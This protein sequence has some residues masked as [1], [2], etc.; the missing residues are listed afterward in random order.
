MAFTGVTACKLAGPP[1]GPFHRRLQPY[2][3]LYGCSDCYRLE[4]KLPGGT[5]SH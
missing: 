4:R 2:R 3:Y 5:A 1:R